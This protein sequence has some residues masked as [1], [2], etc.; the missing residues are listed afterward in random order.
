[1]F[2]PIEEPARLIWETIPKI[3]CLGKFA[4]N[5]SHFWAWLIADG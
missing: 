2:A 5:V 1:M 4:V 3:S